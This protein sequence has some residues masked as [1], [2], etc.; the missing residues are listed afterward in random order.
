MG[1]S[2]AAAVAIG[3]L[4]VCVEASAQWINY[5]TRGIPRTAD[6]KPNLSAP[7]PKTADGKPDLTGIWENFRAPAPA[8]AANPKAPVAN[9]DI[10]SGLKTNDDFLALVKKSAFWNIGSSF[11]DGLPFQPW[12]AELHKQRVADNSKEN[13]DAHVLPMG[14]MQFH[15]HG[16]PRKMIQTPQVIVILYEANA[17]VRQ[18]FTDGQ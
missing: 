18:I 13:P 7:T 10:F 5:P 14:I 17:G 16:Q 6:G 11:P 3:A 9:G 12:A 15:N 4:L 1:M 8:P 2:V